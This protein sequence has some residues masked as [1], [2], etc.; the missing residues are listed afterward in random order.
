MSS[1]WFGFTSLLS[2]LY[3]DLRV[4]DRWCVRAAEFGVTSPPHTRIHTH[5]QETRQITLWRI[6]AVV[7]HYYITFPRGDLHS[8]CGGS[9]TIVLCADAV[10]KPAAGD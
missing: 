6:E 10:S 5:T 3:A 1:V 2:P 9:T 4:R 8:L 7:P